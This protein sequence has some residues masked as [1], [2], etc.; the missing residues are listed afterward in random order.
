MKYNDIK[1]F[2]EKAKLIPFWETNLKEYHRLDIDESWGI[3]DKFRE[4]NEFT[5]SDL[6]IDFINGYI[7]D[8]Y[9]IENKIYFY[10]YTHKFWKLDLNTKI[11]KPYS[12]IQP[13]FSNK[14]FD[15]NKCRLNTLGMSLS[16]AIQ[17]MKETIYNYE[18]FCQ[19][20]EDNYSLVKKV[21]V[22]ND[23]YDYSC[24]LKKEESEKMHNWQNIHMKKYHKGYYKGYHGASPVS[25]FEVRF[26]SCSLGSYADCF[27]T[28]CE[29]D[30]KTCM[31]KDL[32]KD[33]EHISKRMKFEIRGL[34]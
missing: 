17:L 29:R 10:G 20:D 33:A 1:Q 24:S 5:L 27:C 13:G 28:L 12:E 26:G 16:S 18:R 7:P 6:D 21:E 25:P 8:S 34:S 31:D 9:I 30:Y 19:Y 4:D 14:I 3:L 15:L 2:V 11:C 32:L 22:A 23:N